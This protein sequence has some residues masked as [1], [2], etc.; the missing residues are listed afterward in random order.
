MTANMWTASYKLNSNGVTVCVFIVLLTLLFGQSDAILS[1]GYY[2]VLLEEKVNTTF[3][4]VTATSLRTCAIACNKYL[5][6]STV[7]T[8]ATFDSKTL[9]CHLSTSQDRTKLTGSSFKT[10][11]NFNCK[12]YILPKQWRT[13]IS[14]LPLY[15]KM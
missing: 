9:E 3:D 14:S 8:A 5:T 4:I 12:Y 1:D 10:L 13:L 2:E 15:Q 6:S 7:C 11:R